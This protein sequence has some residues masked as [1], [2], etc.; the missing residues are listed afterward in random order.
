MKRGDTVRWLVDDHT[1]RVAM[2]NRDN[3]EVAWIEEVF[4]KGCACSQRPFPVNPGDL[5]VLD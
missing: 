5:E 4:G 3:A 1:Y 2:P